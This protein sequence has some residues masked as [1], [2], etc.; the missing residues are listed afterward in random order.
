MCI[1]VA[2]ASLEYLYV[3]AQ[4]TSYTCYFR[5]LLLVY[6]YLFKSNLTLI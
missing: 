2:S 4:I 3:L 1:F 6:N 5:K